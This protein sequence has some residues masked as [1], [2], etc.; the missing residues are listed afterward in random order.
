MIRLRCL[1]L[2]Y[3]VD[4]QHRARGLSGP[5]PADVE[6]CRSIRPHSGEQLGEHEFKHGSSELGVFWPLCTVWAIS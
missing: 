3:E 6:G 1:A 2:L 4:G 5:Y